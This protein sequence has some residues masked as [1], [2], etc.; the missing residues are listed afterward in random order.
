MEIGFW[1]SVEGFIGAP[2]LAGELI[3]TKGG[4]DVDRERQART[5]CGEN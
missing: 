3:G 2:S 1:G 5:T 4:R